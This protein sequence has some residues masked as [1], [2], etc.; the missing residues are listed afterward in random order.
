[1]HHLFRYSRWL[2]DR[3]PFSIQR[4]LVFY[5]R[6][7]CQCVAL[8][9][10]S[11]LHTSPVHDD[12]AN[13]FTPH[14]SQ[15]IAMTGVQHV[16]INY[17]FFL[18]QNPLALRIYYRESDRSIKGVRKSA[19]RA[20]LAEQLS[21]LTCMKRYSRSVVPNVNLPSNS[22]MLITRHRP[23]WPMSANHNVLLIPFL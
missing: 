12:R 10:H 16:M 7:A 5:A 17:E 22:L 2:N 6:F 3:V 11:T 18:C 23:P 9:V 4:V 20:S 15:L 21:R 1:M 19:A 8:A 14:A 13:H